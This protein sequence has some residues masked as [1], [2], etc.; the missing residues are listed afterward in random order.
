MFQDDDNDQENTLVYGE[1]ISVVEGEAIPK[2]EEVCLDDLAKQI[3][4][5]RVSRVDNAKDIRP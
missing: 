2:R 4:R 5:R 1:R 3:Q